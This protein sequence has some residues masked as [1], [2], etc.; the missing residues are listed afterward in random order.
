MGSLY[1]CINTANKELSVKCKH[2]NEE[3]AGSVSEFA[4]HS[5]W[6]S[7]NPKVVQYRADNA[8]RGVKL[9]NARFG[10]VK[11]YTVVCACCGDDF[12]VKEREQLYP[13]KEQYFCSRACANSTGGKAKA[14]KHHYD[15]VA[16]YVTVAWRHHVKKCLVCGEVKIVAVHHY[17][18][19]HEN[20]DP[21]NLVPLCPTHHQYMHSKYRVE[22]ADAVEE[23]ISNKWGQTA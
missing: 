10:D 6:C 12:I 5:R 18:E 11:A 17:D 7:K 2:C 8:A 16:H 23:Y 20:N 4:N 15:D 22:I 9:G 21:K 1:N 3:F 14:L 19:N 13:Q